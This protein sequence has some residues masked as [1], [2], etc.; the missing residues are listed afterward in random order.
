MGVDITCYVELRDN[1]GKWHI[2]P[3]KRQN[4]YAENPEKWV[5]AE[6]WTGRD[7]ELFSILTDGYNSID[8]PRGLPYDTSDEVKAERDK[9]R[10]FEDGQVSYEGAYDDTYYTLFELEL[11]LRDRKKYPKYYKYKDEFGNKVKEVGPYWRL[12]GFVTAIENF[13]D[14]CGYY[15]PND[16]RILMWFD[17]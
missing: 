1:G 9:F 13:A 4:K 17:R 11:A 3:V 6:P 16:V 15:D 10:E 2:A 7:S 8:S 14:L 5:W 12:K